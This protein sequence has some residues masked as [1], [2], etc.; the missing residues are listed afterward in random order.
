VGFS[1]QKNIKKMASPPVWASPPAIPS[2]LSLFFI[3]FIY[4]LLF[5][6]IFPISFSEI[7][8]WV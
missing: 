7:A 4:F 3:F 8:V 6:F 1:S 5:Y 2:V